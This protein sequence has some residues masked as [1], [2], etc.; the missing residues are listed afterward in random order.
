MKAELQT[1]EVWNGG[2]E[3]EI[4]SCG[5]NCCLYMYTMGEGIG[6]ATFDLVCS[7]LQGL[8]KAFE[9]SWVDMETRSL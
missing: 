8:K 3:L 6:E 4:G 7:N 2:E 5:D 1:L 9:K